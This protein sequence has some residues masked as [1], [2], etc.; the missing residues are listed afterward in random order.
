M[1]ASRCS[2]YAARPH[3]TRARRSGPPID[4]RTPFDVAS[5]TKPMATVAIAMVLVGERRLD[6]AAPVRALAARRRDRGHGARSCS[7]TPPA[8]PRTSSSS[9]ALRAEHAGRSARASW[10]PGRAR[11]A[12]PPPGVQAVY[13]D[14]GYIVLGAVSSAPAAARS[15]GVRATSSRGR[16]ASAR[17][18]PAT[19]ASP[20]PSRPSSTSAALV[21]GPRARRERLLRRRRVRPRRAVRADRRCR[22]VRRRDRRCRRR[23]RAAVAPESSR[24]SSP[25][26]RCRARRGG[27]AGTRPRA[28]PGVSAAGDRWPREHAVGHI[29]FTG[30]SIWLDLPR[31]R[32]VVLLTNR[33][34]PT[35]LAGRRR[36]RSRRCA[37]LSTMRSSTRSASRSYA[38]AHRLLNAGA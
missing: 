14:L 22:E 29:G 32:W 10:S 18:S 5:L 12:R 6:L 3:A 1:P 2:G 8:A 19:T 28:T 17:A 24:A 35:R 36:R 30:T 27:S 33:V 11:A 20:A 13:S 7:A 21:V 34:H 37:V 16:S 38:M 23:Q 26:P 31:R 15:S 4:E 25:S 9:A